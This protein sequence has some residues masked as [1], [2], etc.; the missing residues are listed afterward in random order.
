MSTARR[1][2]SPRPVSVSVRGGA[3]VAVGGVAV[4]SVREDWLVETDWW[5]G[6]VLR[7]RYYQLVLVDGAL[8]TVFCDLGSGQWSRHGG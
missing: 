6:R 7:R 5:T 3:P 1:V 4:D 8:A 2:N